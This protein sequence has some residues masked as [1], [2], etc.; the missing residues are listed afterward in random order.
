MSVLTP[1]Q[2]QHAEDAAH[3]SGARGTLALGVRQDTAASLAGTNGD[4]TAPIFDASGRQHVINSGIEKAEDSAHV[5][6]DYGVMALAVRRDALTAFAGTTGD[7]IPLATDEIGKLYVNTFPFIKHSYQ[8][9][10]AIATT[11]Q[12]YALYDL[13]GTVLTL[14]NVLGSYSFTS[15]GIL[16]AINMSVV[17]SVTPADMYV[18]LSYTDFIQDVSSVAMDGDPLELYGADLQ[19]IITVVKFAAADFIPLYGGVSFAA[20]LLSQPIANTT[21]D[22]IYGAIV[23]G[24]TWNLTGKANAIEATFLFEK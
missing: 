18:V 7:Y 21:G 9:N 19:S 11:S 13:M 24:G 3:S 1:G 12:S 14:N 2:V 23:A 5:S 4:Y 17:K 8:A 6:G 22:D 15:M 20:K 16:K 10:S